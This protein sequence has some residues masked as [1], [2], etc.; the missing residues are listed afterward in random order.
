VLLPRAAVRRPYT[1]AVPT[2]GRIL[3]AALTALAL[4]AITT[5][6]VAWALA[7][8]TRFNAIEWTADDGTFPSGMWYVQRWEA[9]ATVPQ[10]WPPFPTGVLPA[11]ARPSAAVRLAITWSKKMDLGGR[12][13]RVKFDTL[14]F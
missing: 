6:A 11:P 7:A 4:A 14:T 13:D 9:N 2:R 3:R 12:A 1:P 10:D 8:R 5:V